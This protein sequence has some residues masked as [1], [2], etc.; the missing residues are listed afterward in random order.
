M[1]YV[2]YPINKSSTSPIVV[3]VHGGA[4]ISGP[5]PTKVDGWGSTYTATNRPNGNLVKSLLNEGYVVVSLLYRLVQYGDNDPDIFANNITIQNQI[6]DV[7]AAV[8]HIRNNF[9][10][11]LKLNANSIQVLGESAGANLALNFAYTKSDVSYVKSVISVSGP[12]NMNQ[13][14]NFLRNKPILYNCFSKFDF[15]NPVLNPTTN[16]VLTSN[17]HFPYYMTYDPNDNNTSNTITALVNSLQ[18]NIGDI[19]YADLLTVSV[20]LNLNKRK[21]DMYNLA[22]SCVGAQQI[23]NNP[24]SNILFTNISP[25]AQLNVSRIVPTFIIHGNNDWLVPY[26]QAT[27]TMRQQLINIGGLINDFVSDGNSNIPTTYPTTGPKHIIKL[28]NDDGYR[29]GVAALDAFSQ[30]HSN[31]D[32]SDNSQTQGDIIK[33]LNGHK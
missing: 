25:C 11:C 23:I 30:G 1:Y 8:T 22:Q 4:W 28:Y 33:W 13:F 5:D 17:T 3:L 7:D 32:V 18:C 19:N 15:R 27:N 24:I 21:M 6:N 20:I 31:H 16:P 26:T 12:T 2:Y 9:P 10:S 29:T 14:A